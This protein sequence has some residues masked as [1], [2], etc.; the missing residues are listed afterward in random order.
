MPAF[1]LQHDKLKTGAN[2]ALVVLLLSILWMLLGIYQTYYQLVSPIIPV[3]II[4]PIIKPLV[5]NA[6]VLTP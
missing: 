1:P 5:W 6:L 2:I 3:S 4:P